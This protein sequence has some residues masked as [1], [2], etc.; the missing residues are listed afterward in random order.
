MRILLPPSEGKTAPSTGPRLAL[1]TLAFPTL[2]GP[3]EQVLRALTALCRDD[4]DRALS[5]LGIGP[6]LGAEVQRNAA[7]PEAPCAPAWHVY[8]GVL[9]TALDPATLTADPAP[10]LIASGLFGLVSVS[11]TH[12]TLP[13]KA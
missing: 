12:L 1:G 6:S 11:Y 13:T 8:T 9:F 7:L 10:L 5:V 2:T 4:P 3:R